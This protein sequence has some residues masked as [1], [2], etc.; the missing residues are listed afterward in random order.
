MQTYRSWVID[1]EKH[2]RVLDREELAWNRR[3]DILM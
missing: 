2:Q 3:E 1:E